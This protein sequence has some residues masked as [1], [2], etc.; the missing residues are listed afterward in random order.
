MSASRVLILHLSY[1]EVQHMFSNL[2]AGPNSRCAATLKSIVAKSL[3]S[4][5]RS[6]VLL[7]ARTLS[8]PPPDDNHCYRW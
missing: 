5:H 2:A 4:L 6:E 3:L 8:R 7:V 1:S